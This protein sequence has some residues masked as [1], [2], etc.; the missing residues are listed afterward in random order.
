LS[1]ENPVIDSIEEAPAVIEA[2]TPVSTP[3][4]ST[5]PTKVSTPTL[6]YSRSLLSG[7]HQFKRSGIDVGR[8]QEFLDLLAKN[9]IFVRVTSGIR[10]GNGSRHNDGHAI[11]I[12]PINGE[13]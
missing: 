11:D 5:T 12:T 9:S 3:S 2:E 8:L 4:S 13:T 6:I 7:Q 10:P 1:E